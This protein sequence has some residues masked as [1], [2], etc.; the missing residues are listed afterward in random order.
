[1]E[2]HRGRGHQALRLHAFWPGPGL[3][4]HC[5]PVDPFY[6]AWKA[7]A[8]NVSTRFVELAGEINT[9]MPAHILERLAQALD[10]AQGRG[11]RGSRILVLGVGYKR[12]LDDLR[13]SPALRLIEALEA[14]PRR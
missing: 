4:G 5:I 11:L 8:H 7:R 3:G 2:G 6:L 12:N 1:M 13:E 10:A 14:A 9:A